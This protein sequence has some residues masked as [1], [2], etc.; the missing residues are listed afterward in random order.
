MISLWYLL[1]AFSSG[2][3]ALTGVEAISNGVPAFRRPQAHN[4]PTTLAM[5]GVIAI[6]MFLGDLVP[7]HPHPRHHGRARNDRSW[8]Q[9]AHTVFGGGVMFYIVQ[10]FTAA[11]LILAANTAYQDFPRLSAILARDRYMPRQFMNR[12]DRLVFSNGVIGLGW[13]RSS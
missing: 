10:A 6:T 11:I 3:T 1:R 8:A 2:S 9:I 12:G 5:M 13:P 4:A 7:R